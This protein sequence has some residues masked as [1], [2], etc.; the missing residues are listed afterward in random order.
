MGVTN[1]AQDHGCLVK[2]GRI[3]EPCFVS[4]S[5]D[6]ETVLKEGKDMPE[7]EKLG[8]IKAIEDGV[9]NL[10]QLGWARNNFNPSNIRMDGEIP[11]IIDF[12]SARPIG[13]TL[14]EKAGTLG[15]EL[16]GAEISQLENAFGLEKLQEW[17]FP[18]GEWCSGIY[19]RVL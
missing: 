12:D 4:Y 17:I 2:D 13:E 7:A 18:R 16:E 8:L 11:V 3:T 15:W 6:L 10:Q 14:G 9:R 5:C 1:F 19:Y